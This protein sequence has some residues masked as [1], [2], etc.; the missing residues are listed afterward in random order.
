MKSNSNLVVTVVVT[1][2]ALVPPI[3]TQG[4]TFDLKVVST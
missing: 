1:S 2:L 3:P 4:A